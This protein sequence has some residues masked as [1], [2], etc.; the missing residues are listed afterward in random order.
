MYGLNEGYKPANLPD[1]D[2]LDA[3]LAFKAWHRVSLALHFVA[4]G[5]VIFY[6]WRVSH[7]TDNLRFVGATTKFRG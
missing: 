4:L 1:A 3:T 2:R 7:P 6:F 5:G